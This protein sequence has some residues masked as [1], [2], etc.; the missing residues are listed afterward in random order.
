MRVLKNESGVDKYG[1]K[2]ANGVLEIYTKK[3][4]LATHDKT[5]EEVTVVGHKLQKGP[6]EGLAVKDGIVIKSAAPS[7]DNHL[8]LTSGDVTIVADTFIVAP[9]LTL[10]KTNNSDTEH[11]EKVFLSA[12]QPPSFPGGITGWEK[13]LQRQLKASI[14]SDKGGPPGK[15]V[16]RVSFMVDENGNLSDF[17]IIKDPGY[18]TGAEA[19]RVIKNGPKWVPATQNGKPVKAM[20]Q[21]SVTWVV[22]E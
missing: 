13:Y 4:G 7:K 19:L 6:A 1:S 16:A 11:Y 22:T 20:Q 3:G 12:M 5:L 9:T 15:Y 14:V 2:A 10:F 17:K 8:M 18:G 21:Q